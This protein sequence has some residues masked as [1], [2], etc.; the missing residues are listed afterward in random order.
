MLI[1]W[2]AIKVI[3][4]DKQTY[5]NKAVQF[6]FK[7]MEDTADK[8]DYKSDFKEA[9]LKGNNFAERVL[10]DGEYKAEKGSLLLS[11][12]ND[13]L[14]ELKPGTYTLTVSLNSGKSASATF[15]V[16]SSI[17]TPNTGD[18]TSASSLIF[19]WV[20]FLLSLSMVV[21]EADVFRF[22][23]SKLLAVPAGISA[24]FCG[25]ADVS[26]VESQTDKTESETKA[27][28]ETDGGIN[29]CIPE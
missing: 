26:T 29:D 21:Y 11:I 24:L 3:K 2:I 5:K 19:A 4:G 18:N 13:L 6:T 20:L 8:Y 23:H 22:L 16:P 1:I 14:K 7:F 27:E 25:N 28:T 15:T 12:E 10:V 9:T 17:N